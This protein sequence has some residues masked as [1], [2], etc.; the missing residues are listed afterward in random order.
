MANS[1]AVLFAPDNKDI[2][3]GSHREHHQNLSKTLFKGLN[4]STPNKMYPPLL[5]DTAFCLQWFVRVS[6]KAI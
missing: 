1:L 6:S 5:G 4:V 3:D 2:K